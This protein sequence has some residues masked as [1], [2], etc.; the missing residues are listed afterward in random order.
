M[1]L[2]ST[3]NSMLLISVNEMCVFLCLAI[4]ILNP[5]YH[6]NGRNGMNDACLL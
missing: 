1:M 5:Q 6:S 3:V 2:A 4:F